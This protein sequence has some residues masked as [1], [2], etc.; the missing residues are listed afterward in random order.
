[1]RGNVHWATDPAPRTRTRPVKFM[2]NE[3]PN[4]LLLEAQYYILSVPRPL[5]LNKIF[6][7]NTKFF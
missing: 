3:P 7:N 2:F 5:F 6:E 1:M 4:Y